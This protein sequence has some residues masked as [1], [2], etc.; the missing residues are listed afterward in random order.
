MKYEATQ[1]DMTQY[2]ELIHRIGMI[3][4]QVQQLSEQR[5]QVIQAIAQWEQQ[6]TVTEEQQHTVTEE[7]QHA[8]TEPV[9]EEVKL[10]D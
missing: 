2:S 1:E 4:Y 6:H 3:D 8:L 9:E 5:N 7:Q 10:E